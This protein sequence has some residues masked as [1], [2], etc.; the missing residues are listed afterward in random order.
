MES[1]S[2]SQHTPNSSVCHVGPTGIQE[3][4]GA[5]GNHRECPL[6]LNQDEQDSD[7]LSGIAARLPGV[8]LILTDF[9]P[10]DVLQEGDP[11]V[12]T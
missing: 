3:A 7:G 9:L 8:G 6:W 12:S 10:T 4:E 2:E 1:S 11:R 5:R